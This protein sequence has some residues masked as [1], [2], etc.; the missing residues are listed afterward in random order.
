MAYPLV[1]KMVTGTTKCTVHPY[2]PYQLNNLFISK[3]HVPNN[4]II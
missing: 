2:L 4:I 1:H 3:P